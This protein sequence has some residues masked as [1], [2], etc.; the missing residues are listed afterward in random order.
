MNPNVP[1]KRLFEARAQVSRI[2]TLS[3]PAAFRG[4]LLVFCVGTEPLVAGCVQL[5]RAGILCQ[6]RKETFNAGDSE[7]SEVAEVPVKRLER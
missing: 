1:R 5:V 7:R 3:L 2:R 6:I 4:P